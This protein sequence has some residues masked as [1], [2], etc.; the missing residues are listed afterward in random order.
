MKTKIF[1]ILLILSSILF[2]QKNPYVILISFDGFRW[3]YCERGITPNLDSFK[4][5]GV[6]AVSLQPVFPSKTFPN[7]YSIITGMYP[8][9]H[10]IIF[11]SFTNTNNGKK[12]RIGNSKEVKNAEWYLGEAFWETANRNGIKTASYFW[13][14][15][16]LNLDYRRPVYYKKYD[17]NKPYIERVEGVIEW[18]KL[19]LKERPR[20]ITLYFHDT[21]TY[22]HNYGPNSPEVNTSIS[23][24][25][26]LMGELNSKLEEI[27]LI[28][29]TNII[30]V[31][32]HGMTEISP[33]RTVN[34]ERMLENYKVKI[35]GSKP[36]MMIDPSKEDFQK[37]FNL[38]KENQNHYKVYLKEDLPEYFHFNKHPYIYPI[39]LVA[40]IGWSLVKDKWLDGMVRM[41]S[42]GNHGYDNH[43]MD[44]HGVFIAKGPSF[45]SGYKCG[46]LFNIDINPLL[47]KIFGIEPISN[48]DGK[49]ENIEFILK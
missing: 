22:G 3:D 15:S 49:I 42:Q 34:I 19:P 48:I 25:D 31:S 2:A 1:I 40:D 13:P 21:D 20:F 37:V 30:V 35:D 29:S 18:L 12:Y 7:H 6:H 16:E 38:L 9:N 4:Q 47:C 17:H 10:G 11:N 26:T 46:T 45:K 36:V 5:E 23:R 24:L 41:K 44:M 14:G 33:E 39:I 28:D 27:G 8:A 43:Q 32:D